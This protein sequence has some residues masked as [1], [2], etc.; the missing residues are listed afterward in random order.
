MSEIAGKVQVAKFG[1]ENWSEFREQLEVGLM[2]NGLYDLISDDKPDPVRDMKARGLIGVSLKKYVRHAIDFT[3]LKTSKE[4]WKK[5]ESAYGTVTITSRLLLEKQFTQV[6]MIPSDSV[7][8]YVSRVIHIAGQLRAAKVQVDDITIIGRM[9]DGLPKKWESLVSAIESVADSTLTI[10]YVIKRL[11][12]QEVKERS[13]DEEA[14]DVAMHVSGHQGRPGPKTSGGKK[15][16]GGRCFYCNKP[17]HKK[18]NCYAFKK[19]N[20][21]PSNGRKDQANVAES[22]KNDESFLF[23]AVDSEAHGWLVDSGATEHMCHVR[24]L[25]NEYYPVVGK[26]VRLANGEVVKVAGQGTVELR[27]NVGDK[28]HTLVLRDVLFVPDLAVALISVSRLMRLGYTAKFGK[29]ECEVIAE[30]GKIVA[31]AQVQ[32]GGIYQLQG[33]IENTAMVAA[34]TK[35]ALWHHRLG[36]LPHASIKMLVDKSMVTGMVDVKD[37]GFCE[38]CVQGKLHASPVPAGQGTRAKRP[39]ELIHS[40]VMGPM[41]TISREGYRYVVTFIDDFTRFA[42]MYPLKE[43]GDVFERFKAFKLLVEKQYDATIKIL[44][45]DNGGEYLSDEF[46]RFLQSSGMLHQLTVPYSPHQNG[47]AERSNRTLMEMARTML[48]YANLDHRYWTDALLTATYL[49]N[50]CPHKS[51]HAKTPFEALTGQK[52]DVTH[53]RV[54]GCEAYPLVPQGLKGKLDS[55]T[56]K[57]IFVGYGHAN[58][59]KGYRIL[60][61][62]TGRIVISKNVAFNEEGQGFNTS[63]SVNVND[64]T[65]QLTAVVNKEDLVLEGDTSED[66]ESPETGSI[67]S[68][69]EGAIDPDPH[70]QDQQDNPEVPQPSPDNRPAMRNKFGKILLYKRQRKPRFPAEAVVA[71]AL[72]AGAEVVVDEPL[73]V[74]EALTGPEAEKWS[75]AIKVEMDSIQKNDVFDL[76]T[77]PPG[78]KAIGSKW[79]FRVKRDSEGQ[80]ERYKARLVAKG[81]SQKEGVDFQETFAPV[82]KFSSIRVLLAI[83]TEKGYDVHQMD[84]KTAFLNGDLE[85]EIFMEQPEGVVEKGKEHLVWRLRKS[86]YGLKQAPRVWY[87]KLDS[88]LQSIGFSRCESDHSV[89]VNEKSK[90]LISVYVD[91]LVIAGEPDE[92]KKTKQL[93]AQEFEMSDLGE[94]HWLLGMKVIRTE[95]G[96]HVNQTQ[97]I[98]SMLDKFG[99]ANCR[100]VSTPMEGKLTAE[101]SSIT[102]EDEKEMKD[103][104][105]RQAVGSLMYVM[106]GTR[107]DLAVALSSVSRFMENPGPDHWTAVKR[108]FRYLRGTSQC[109]LNFVSHSGKV[110]LVG[111]CDADWAGDLDTRKSTTG[112]VF[113]VAGGSVTWNC[114][115]QP[116]VALSST[117]AEYMSLCAAGR[118]AVWLRK[119]LME[120]GYDQVGPTTIFA[121][122]QGSLALAKN[123]VYHSRTK[124]IDVQHHFIRELIQ[125]KVIVLQYVPTADNVAD[126]LTKPLPASKHL[127]FMKS[128]GLGESS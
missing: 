86:L 28:T 95:A 82:A 59:I 88:F 22:K 121:D 54:F 125:K 108:I 128:M 17:G 57:G 102:A 83:A 30:N 93:L 104:P 94:L 53:L 21:G 20:A 5:L 90:V 109:G 11:V 76:T 47:V 45:S 3:S 29:E 126:V 42:W 74:T 89:Y 68:G 70:Q 32:R 52:P 2:A 96:I 75:E 26:T 50:R 12:N 63:S 1:G 46:K 71:N 113:S 69:P 99:M 37:V 73:T 31:L 25:F 60:D 123:P 4:V 43:K 101:M 56:K 35:N 15:G 41:A 9:L 27:A 8:S 107:P 40:D 111:Y 91:D 61:T 39:L 78:R 18:A 105:Y 49:K 58:G 65:S 24:S 119:L 116:T 118:E 7:Q 23:A 115:R 87:A 13:T 72:L 112:Y 16:F 19:N 122:N 48:I 51:V 36:H 120:L 92:V 110:Q 80:T 67:A 98:N 66:G 55:K 44:R 62:T 6:R 85:E 84:V 77:L 14:N 33:P 114:K 103:V 79:V 64:E 106:V 81:F 117:E 97:Y 124:H 127:Q 100:P 34:S 38:A 10:D